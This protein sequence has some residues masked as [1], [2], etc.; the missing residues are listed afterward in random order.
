MQRLIFR[1]SSQD[2]TK[3]RALS[4]FRKKGVLGTLSRR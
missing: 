2:R 3:E 4:S 1:D